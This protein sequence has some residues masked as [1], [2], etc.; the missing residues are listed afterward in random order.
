MKSGRININIYLAVLLAVL[1]LITP[2]FSACGSGNNQAEAETVEVR[3]RST[4]PGTSMQVLLIPR[5]ADGFIVEAEADV[6]LKLY[7]QEGHFVD[8]A[9][10]DLFQQWNMHITADDYTYLLG[11]VIELK[12]DNPFDYASI[13]GFLEVN[14]VMANGA[15]FA[16]DLQDLAVS[17]EYSC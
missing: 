7:L 6:E 8:I 16:L 17:E 14:A 3:L 12:F 9:K 10:G 1:V 2:V 15:V 4:T 11:A 5:D 13:F